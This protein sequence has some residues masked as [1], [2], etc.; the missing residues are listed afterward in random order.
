MFL[1]TEY[2]CVSMKLSNMTLIAMSTSSLWTYS[3]RCM[4]AWA[5]AIRMMDSMCLTVMGI[6][7]VLWV[8][9]KEHTQ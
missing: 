5:S 2:F 1:M 9:G 4:R 7:P 3:L 6:L 8:N